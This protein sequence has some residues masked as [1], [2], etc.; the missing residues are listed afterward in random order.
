MKVIVVLLC[1]VAA[2]AA[3]DYVVDRYM[4][5]TGVDR[6]RN[7]LKAVEHAKIVGGV[8]SAPHSRPF[9]VGLFLTMEAGTAFCGGSLI[10][11]SFVMTAAHCV[12]DG[13]NTVSQFEAVLGAHNIYDVANSVRIQSKTAFMHPGWNP[14]TLQND[15]ALIKL[16]TDAPVNDNIQ[17][18]VLPPYSAV[19]SSFN[20]VS[21]T[22]SGWGK[23]SDNVNQISEVLREVTA[24]V[25]ANTV[26]N[27]RYLGVIQSTHVCVDGSN[28]KGSCNGDS[29]G[30]LTA[31]YNGRK[32]QVGIVSFGIALGCEAGWPP[33]YTRVTSYLDW[34]SSTS[35]MKVAII[36][37][38]LVAAT[39]AKEIV[40]DQFMRPTGA[41]RFRNVLKAVEHARIVGGVESV[42]HSKPYQV[43]IFLTMA[44]GTAFCGGSLISKN[45]VMTA[46]HC[47]DDGRNTVSL[48]TVVLGAHN[49]YD[50]E[51]SVRIQS[52][53]AYVHTAWNHITLQ[54]DIA[55]IKLPTDAPLNENIQPV[56]LPP[57]SAA[58]LSFSGY[59]TTVSGWG[60]SSDNVNQISENLREVSV[61][62][63]SNNLCNV[64]YLGIIQS[65]HICT[66]GANGKG[67][68]N[69]DSGGPLTT[70]LNGKKVQI[71]IV[72]FG[73]SQ[74]CEVGYPPVYSRVTSFLFW[75]SAV[76]GI[77]IPT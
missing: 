75:I 54:N 41:E 24:D 18:A 51:N 66:D 71:G 77:E 12:Y 48:F 9:Q 10:S 65:S 23:P 47:V 8:E 49:I 73:S 39:V 57:Y 17:P 70:M 25:I 37:L 7:V 20:G 30:P 44:A 6:F 36:L 56:V 64:R 1:F 52:T 26:C 22:V 46:A 19:G 15:I 42:P 58:A 53:T 28:G 38:C 72:S 5:P 4:S 60:K 35:G 32:I 13:R 55:V 76:T 29:G 63:I 74:G 11:R 33:V 62:A 69:G 31:V 45:Y 40:I 59:S 34:I 14:S 2:A 43:G 27:V 16:P 61:P 21:A 67:S 3:K 68:C 50:E